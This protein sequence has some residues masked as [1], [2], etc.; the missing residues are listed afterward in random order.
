MSVSKKG[1]FLAAAAAFLAFLPSLGHGWTNLDDPMFL[2]GE[3]GWRGLGPDAVAWAFTSKVGSVYQPL[4]WLTYGLDHALWGMDPF[5]FH[6]QSVLWHAIS[7]GLMFLIARRLLELARPVRSSDP[8]WGLNAAAFLSAMVFSVHP[9]RAES[10]SWASERRDVVCCAFVLAAVWAYLRPRNRKLVFALF[11]LSLLSKGMALLLPVALLALDVYPLRRV[12]PRGEG[13][14]TALKEKL[15]LFALAF[16][17]GLVGLAAQ[18]RIRWTWEQ[19]ALP[20]RLAQACFALLFYVRKTLWPSGLM[21]LYEL[22]PP[23]DPAEP[24]FVAAAAAVAAAA[25]VCWRRRLSRPWL[26]ASAFWYAVL[27]FPVSGLFQF[28]PQL[29]AD[30]YSYITTLPLA[31][32]A[33]AALR[34][35]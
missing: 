25:L 9:L 33:G 19:H 13:L 29:V 31:V 34:E 3:T 27:L 35:G 18:E 20:A 17:F 15:P 6:L 1:A 16:V 26:A 5:G 32:L 22:R 23:L 30:R 10:V 12:G 21:P 2:L 11:L 7:A 4:A 8:D 14:R 24:R 28:G